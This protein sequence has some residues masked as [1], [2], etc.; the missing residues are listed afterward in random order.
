MSRASLDDLR[1][2]LQRSEACASHPPLARSQT[3]DEAAQ[4]WERVRHCSEGMRREHLRWLGR[5]DLWFL[6]VY[7]LNRRHFMADERKT[8]WTFERCR[9]V[10]ADP[11]NHLDIWHREAY[12]SEIITFG[13]TIQDILNDPEL[14][15]GFF[16]HTRPMAKDFLVLIKREFEGNDL[17]KEIFD[18]ILWQDP[19]L[20]CRAASVSWSEND[21]ITVKRRGN[22]KEATIE[23]WGLVD[24]QPTGKRYKRL[25]YDDVVSRDS[26]SEVMIHQTS[27]QFDNSLLLTASD[28]PIFRYIATFQEIGD[29][30]QQL[31]DRHVGELRMRKP[32]DGE[33]K[34]A[35]LSDE[36]F[37][38]FK[39]NL[40]P[41]VF[42][43]QILL[44]PKQSIDASEMGFS[45]EWLE[46]WDEE[47]TRA[48]TN[49]YIVVDPAG[50]ARTINS[51]S[52][53][54]MWVVGLRAD[55]R[56]Y[57]LDAA[58]DKYD[59]AERWQVLLKAVAKW[60]PLKVGY[61]KYGMQSDIEYFRIEMRKT[62]E[63]FPLVELGGLKDKDSRIDLLKPPFKEKRIL[64]PSK[65]IRKKLKD[66]TEVDLIRQFIDREYSL[67]PYTKSKDMLD[68]L[69]RLF[70][71]GFNVTYPRRYGSNSGE[72]GSADGSIDGGMGGWMSG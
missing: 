1:A 63:S 9:E 3:P 43:L 16:S 60:E 46:Y 52:R 66:G 23:A 42:A 58:C 27:E 6:L 34:P 48:G 25:V 56:I 65:G 35:C 62:N 30:T 19:K 7:L 33:G 47:P 26:I 70:D 37:A 49:V 2:A 31:I 45:T 20:E 57:V 29:T 21:G 10:Q 18:D 72:Y 32:L 71:P 38:W 11:N 61:E 4:W 28:P 13:L 59:L 69:A 39:H 15:F 68:A 51:N 55:K 50:E 17:L 24:G 36:K 54:A 67:F 5:N 14:T 12:K 64:F 53:F 44:D 41:K 8:K 40:S 22:P